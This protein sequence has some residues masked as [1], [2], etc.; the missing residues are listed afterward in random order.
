MET[1]YTGC[2]KSEAQHFNVCNGGGES[3]P[4]KGIDFSCKGISQSVCA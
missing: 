2:A 1:Y 4:F 3:S